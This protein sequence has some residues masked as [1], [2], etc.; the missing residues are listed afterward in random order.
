MPGI[1]IFAR[2]SLAFEGSIV[3]TN[4]K[5]LFNYICVFIQRIIHN[6]GFLDKIY[7]MISYDTFR[8]AYC[9]LPPSSVF[10]SLSLPKES[11]CSYISD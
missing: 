6:K 4:N 8:H 9:F 10:P 7:S 3:S 2:W 1:G 5:I 11:S